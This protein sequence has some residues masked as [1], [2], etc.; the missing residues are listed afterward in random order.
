MTLHYP[1]LPLPTNAIGKF[2][3]FALNSSRPVIN[4]YLKANA[5]ACPEAIVPF[6]PNPKVTLYPLQDG[7][8]YVDYSTW[9][10]CAVE[11]K[12]TREHASALVCVHA[13]VCMCL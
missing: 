13:C 4:D 11:E 7:I 8:G 9:C 10:V 1:E 6:I 3:R 12:C 5:I 2:C